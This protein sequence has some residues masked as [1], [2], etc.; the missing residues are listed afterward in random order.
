MGL[1]P[2]QRGSIRFEGAEIAGL[3]PH[4]VAAKGIGYTPQGRR[5]WPSLTVDEHLR[6]AASGSGAWT[7]ER[8][9]DTFPRLAERRG[10]GGGQLSGGEQQMLAI[11]RAL[12]QDPRLL[13][14]DEPT[15]GLAPVVVRQ[16]AALLAPLAAEGDVAI[17]LIEQTIPVA[18]ALAEDFAIMVN[19]RLERVMPALVLSASIGGAQ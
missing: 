8:V 17:L 2:V 12:L 13:V 9:Y 15:E 6:L 16:V 3:A 18:T 10:N 7:I 4:Q 5:L 11:A 19:V 1:V 14:L